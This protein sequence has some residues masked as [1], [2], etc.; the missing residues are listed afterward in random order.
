[1]EGMEGATRLLA[2]RLRDRLPAK[3]AALRARY[4]VTEL[5]AESLPDFVTVDHRERIRLGLEEWPACLVVGQETRRIRRDDRGPTATTFTARYNLR[6]F[7]MVRAAVDA[8]ADLARKRLTLAVRE[9]LLEQ[10]TLGAA[11]TVDETSL[12]ESY[13]DLARDDTDAT[14][15]GAFIAVDVVLEESLTGLTAPVGT[16]AAATVDTGALPQHPAL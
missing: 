11:G 6:V 8:D 13:S 15:A 14:V 16:V 10:G 5:A 7:V 2:D 9:L 3:T 1:M 12:T 4:G